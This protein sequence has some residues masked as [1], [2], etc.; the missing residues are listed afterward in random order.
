M[1]MEAQTERVLP[2]LGLP[3]ALLR[4]SQPRCFVHVNVFY[5]RAKENANRMPFKE[6]RRFSF[7]QI[8]EIVQKGAIFC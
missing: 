7:L 1:S 3:G 4:T 6:T 8:A 5:D 2:R